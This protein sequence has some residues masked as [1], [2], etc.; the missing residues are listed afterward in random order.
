MKANHPQHRIIIFILILLPILALISVSP[1]LK[2]TS[3]RDPGFYLYAGSRLLQGDELYTEIWDHKPPLI[4]LVNALGL[5]ISA[6][7][8]WGVWLLE[9]ASLIAATLLAFTL[10]RSSFGTW[11]SLLS[12]AAGLG[13]LV[14]ILHGGN[15][16][17]EFAILYQVAV[18]YFFVQYRRTQKTISALACGVAIGGLFFLRQNLIAMGAAITL[19]ILWLAITHRAW[20]LRDLL[21][22]SAGFL[23]VVVGMLLF[24]ELRSDLGEFW[25]AAFIYN[26]AY[27]SLGLAERAKAIGTG[28]VFLARSPLGLAILVGWIVAVWRVMRH[29]AR[30]LIR[31]LLSRWVGGLLLMGGILSLGAA[32][33]AEIV[34]QAQPGFGL[35]QKAALFLGAG[36]VIFGLVALILRRHLPQLLKAEKLPQPIP[37][38]TLDLITIVVFWLP[39]EIVLVT[40]SG[41]AY[42]HY[43]MPLFVGGLFLL[44]VLLEQV[45]QS[46]SALQLKGHAAILT[47]AWALWMLAGLYFFPIVPLQDLYSPRSDQQMIAAAQWIRDNSQPDESVLVWG[48][49]PYVNF[50]SERRSPTRYAYLYPLITSNEAGLSRGME[51]VAALEINPP[52]VIIDAQD[53]DF[54]RLAEACASTSSPTHPGMAVALNMLC[55]NYRF[56]R[57][58]GPEGWGVFLK[59]SP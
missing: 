17:E 38:L 3:P 53:D 58:I 29:Y 28:I 11:V 19:D 20:P 23:G 33:A 16:T 15:Y 10:L 41:R 12:I 56:E 5:W 14:Q 49:E 26:Q 43:F 46:L 44:A 54:S 45:E 9:A 22:I 8:V 48:A 2:Q 30:E 18:L 55:R 21:K 6:G 47:G 35:A 1:I 36:L 4:H 52:A 40:L 42:L 25:Q 34:T 13:L 57:Q 27:S 7:S 24:I 59:N 31:G 39:I 32:F 37:P 51:F 50:L